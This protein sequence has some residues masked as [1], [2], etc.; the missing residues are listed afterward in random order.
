MRKWRQEPGKEKYTPLLFPHQMVKKCI[1][2]CYPAGLQQRCHPSYLEQCSVQGRAHIRDLHSFLPGGLKVK[3]CLLG[4]SWNPAEECEPNLTR[5]EG[6][7][8]PS[9][10]GI[11]ETAFLINL[12]WKTDGKFSPEVNY[13]LVLFQKEVMWLLQ[14]VC[15]WLYSPSLC[16][17]YTCWGWCAGNCG[18]DDRE[19]DSLQFIVFKA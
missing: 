15:I 4:R 6:A 7:A 8:H 12:I 9:F 16:W 19:R 2:G 14:A 18:S 10:H 13:Y 11:F 1:W 5:P 17:S 3:K